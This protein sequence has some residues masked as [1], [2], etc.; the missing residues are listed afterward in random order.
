MHKVLQSLK[1]AHDYERVS[2]KGYIFWF[3]DV[4]RADINSTGRW[5]YS[6]GKE[7]ELVS[8]RSITSYMQLKK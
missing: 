4:I 2:R 5:Q 8:V 6:E 1:F 3:A 7:F